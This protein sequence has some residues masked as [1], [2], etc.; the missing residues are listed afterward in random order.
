MRKRRGRSA[1]L[2]LL[3][4]FFT[5][6]STSIARADQSASAAA[7]SEPAEASPGEAKPAE[8]KLGDE[9]DKPAEAP[10]APEPPQLVPS[11]SHDLQFGIAVLFG[12][13][14]RIIFPYS[15][16]PTDCGDANNMG[17]RVCTNRAPSFIDLQPSFGIS[18]SWDFLVDLRLGIEKDFNTF[19]Q[20]F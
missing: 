14:Y 2:P 7:A 3:A 17:A 15:S 19:R 9:T 4:V 8:A 1:I 11:L 10:P 18:Q 12:D 6:A 13:G 20:L 16:Q 5:F